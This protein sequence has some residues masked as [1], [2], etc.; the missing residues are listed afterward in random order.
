MKI[1]QTP[2]YFPNQHSNGEEIIFLPMGQ[3]IVYL[4]FH[5]YKYVV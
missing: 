3:T 2:G 4:S 1:V 5:A